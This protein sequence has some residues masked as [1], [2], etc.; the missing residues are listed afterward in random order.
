MSHCGN[1]LTAYCGL[2]CGDCVRYKSRAADLARDLASELQRITFDRYAKVKSASVTEL[3]HYEECLRVLEAI[4][5][6]KC[7]TPCRAGGDGCSE[8]CEIK[9]CVQ[10]GNLEGCWKCDEFERCERFDFLKR[11]HGDAPQKNLRKIKRYGLGEWVQHR[12]G[13]FSWSK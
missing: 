13:F 12:E 1:E 11:Y 5:K 7:N 6:L 4:A 9:K 8:P 10:S 2:Y 3:G